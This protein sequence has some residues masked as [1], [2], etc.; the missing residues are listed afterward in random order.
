[1]GEPGGSAA[2]LRLTRLTKRYEGLVAVEDVDLEVAAGEFLTLLGP[3]GSGKTTTLNMIAGFIE[4][5]SGEIT[6]GGKAISRTAPHERNIGVVFQHYVLFPH[7]TVFDN[8]AF[9]LRRRGVRGQELETRVA[10]ALGLV[11]LEG[12]GRRYPGQ[13]SGGQ[14]QRVALARAVVFRPSLLLMDEPMGALDKKLRE[15]LQREIRRI[16]RQVGITFVHVTHDQEEALTMSDRI[17]VMNHGRL[18][19]VDRPQELYERPNSLFTAR[20]LGDAN[21]FEEARLDSADGR[22]RAVCG[23]LAVPVRFGPDERPGDTVSVVVRPE[24]IELRDAADSRPAIDSGVVREVVYMGS[25]RKVVIELDSGPTLLATHSVRERSVV[26][27]G[28]RFGVDWDA[29]ASVV[30]PAADGQAAEAPR[31]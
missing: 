31:G 17:A 1:V 30:L 10:E 24:Q 13:L 8:V 21:V 23:R 16:Q 3:S 26:D 2:T 29:E 9:P 28:D 15:T 25:I 20:F 18:I 11:Q 4:P 19:Q 14:Q 7:M 5:T 12:V 6:L 22:A 27:V